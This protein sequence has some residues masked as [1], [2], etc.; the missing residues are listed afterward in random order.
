MDAFD[1]FGDG[2]ISFLGLVAIGWSLTWR[3]RSALI[4]GT[5]LLL[6]AI[7]VEQREDA[8]G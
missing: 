3:A 2:L 8:H 6:S 4:Q 5:V 7:N 1:F